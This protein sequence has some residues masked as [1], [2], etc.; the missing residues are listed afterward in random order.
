MFNRRPS[1]EEVAVL[2]EAQ[3]LVDN[4]LPP[5][6]LV[7]RS[8]RWGIA[9]AGLF[10][11]PVWALLWAVFW[12]LAFDR[13]AGR[14]LV[15]VVPVAAFFMVWRASVYVRAYHEELASAK[16]LLKMADARWPKD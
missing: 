2:V 8:V 15:L 10:G 12:M 9:D 16:S 11:V 3:R 1:I 6:K 4:P 14:A 5:K 7:G 13:P